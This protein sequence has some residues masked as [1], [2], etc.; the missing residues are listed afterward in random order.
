MGDW[1]TH[2]AR[3]QQLADSVRRYLVA[4]H[5][6]GIAT[7]LAT[8][9]SLAAQ[10]IHP[11]WALWPIGVFAI[12]LLLAGISML[13][14]QHREMKRRDAAKAGKEDPEFSFLWWSWSWN[15]LSLIVFVGAVA[16]ALWGLGSISLAVG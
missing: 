8:A 1:Q 16:A 15:W 14:A 13:L 3:S 9:S 5:T 4:A 7:V 12:G 11:R 10:Q 6:G 2:E